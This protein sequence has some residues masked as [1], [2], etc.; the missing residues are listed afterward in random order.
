MSS[1]TITFD[2]VGARELGRAF[3]RWEGDDARIRQLTFT[4]SQL[5]AMRL[6]EG[7]KLQPHE[8]KSII[9][10]IHK[11]DDEDARMAGELL[12]KAYHTFVNRYLH[13]HHPKVAVI[14]EEDLV[15]LLSEPFVLVYQKIRKG[16]Y[17]A[18]ENIKFTTYLIAFAKNLAINYFSEK[19]RL[20]G[21]VAKSAVLNPISLETPIGDEENG[22]TLGDLIGDTAK[23]PEEILMDDY[24]LGVLKI[25]VGNDPKRKKNLTADQREVV[26]LRA[27]GYSMEEICVT[28]G[29][30]PKN[31]GNAAKNI[32]LR[33]RENIKEL[34]LAELRE[35][36]FSEKQL[37]DIGFSLDEMGG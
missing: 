35:L 9:L 26:M 31:G 5:I 17:Y 19:K 18:Q 1:R 25:C 14:P 11:A 15:Y 37:K 12:Y 30:S 23:S 7:D 36:G 4:D 33:A 20:A 3:D 32:Y 13:R 34:F 28:M 22:S 16:R 21:N 29:K 6:E 27:D 24:I 10:T 8:I 2:P